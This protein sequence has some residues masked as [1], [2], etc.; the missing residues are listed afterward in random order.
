MSELQQGGSGAW[1][2][3]HRPVVLVILDGWGYSEETE[4]NAIHNADIPV[5]HR[6]WENGQRMLIQCSGR[7]VGLPDGQM[8][9]SEVGHMHIGAGRL[10]FQE[11]S[12]INSAIED[13][14]FFDNE[15][16]ISRLRQT[17]DTGKAVHLLGLLSP[18]GVHSHE[19]H[20]LSMIELAAGCGVEHV[21][22][23]AFLDGRDTPPKSAAESLQAAYLKFRELDCGRIVSIIGRYYAMDRN[24]HWDRTRIAY[25]LIVNGRGIHQT[26]D[27]LI[28]L[29]LAYQRDET[30]EF[31]ESTCICPSDAEPVA[32]EDGDLVVFMNFRAD[33]ARQLT[34]SLSE[35]DFDE[36]KR[37]RIPKLGGF[38]T[39]TEY[40]EDFDLPVMFP[41]QHLAN[42]FGEYIAKLGLH[43]LR[44]AETEKYAHVTFFFNGGEERVFAGE[45]RILVPSPHVATYD[46]APEMSADE[47]TDRL[48]EAIESDKYDAIICN[49]ANADMVGHTGDYEA[50]VRAVSFLDR[51][52]GRILEAIDRQGG[53]LL[54]TADHG[55]AEKMRGISTKKQPGQVHTA[56]TD[57]PIPLVYVGRT[58]T[59]ARTGSLSDV[60]P[61]LLYLMG[62]PQPAE[63]TGKPL[64]QLEAEA[65][66]QERGTESAADLEAQ[67]ARN[68]A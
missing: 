48:I 10:I 24:R 42:V 36:F 3:P 53:E 47:V 41:P 54:I 35:P 14:S 55:N 34:R 46:E 29:D 23:H 67:H 15:T 44:I 57:N 52:L 4:Y 45:D 21:Y 51:C 11:L 8:G 26:T 49:F 32:I 27:P 18:G 19:D 2:I 31:V 33:R 9:N 22:L 59:M 50:T 30:D 61:T 37:A 68:L 43:Q 58:A 1:Q 6:L 20:I 64:V 66:G 56:H 60:A 38:L 16:A 39:L 12:R 25:N 28:A 7:E 62:L 65:A 13:G 5:W 63:M 40:S 17:S